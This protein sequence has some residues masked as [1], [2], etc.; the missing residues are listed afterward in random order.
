MFDPSQHKDNDRSPVTPG[1]KVVAFVRVG[2]EAT[3]KNGATF[4]PTTLVVLVD[5]NAAPGE[6]G[7]KGALLFDDLF[8]GEKSAWRLAQVCRAVKNVTPFDPKDLDQLKKRLML[9][10]DG[11]SVALVVSVVNESYT[12]NDGSTGTKAK[13]SAF[14]PYGG[15]W[16]DDFDDIIEKG[17]ANAKKAAEKRGQK[18]GGGSGSGGSGSGGG[19]RQPSGN[20]GLP[21]GA[22][23]DG[24]GGFDDDPIP[25]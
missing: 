21:P 8:S 7:D 3:T 2:A 18:S 9:A 25:F 24:G 13:I 6:K 23:S 1:E 14:K 11:G 10:E 16:G 19:Q 4:N 20:D 17:E 15:A 5:R 22:G 12:K